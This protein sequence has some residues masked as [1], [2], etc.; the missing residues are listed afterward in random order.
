[1]ELAEF[2]VAVDRWLDEQ[3]RPLAPEYEGIGTLDQQMAQ[4]RKVM[5][6]TYEAGFMRMGWPERVGGLGGSNLLRA[7]L[8]EVLTARDIVEPGM[9]SMP[10]VLAPTMIDYAPAGL[11]AQMVP[12]LL[13]GE[14]T[15]CQGFSEP[16]TGSNLGSLACRA[17]PADDGWTVQGQKVWTS[18]AQYAARCVLLARTGTPESAHRG[19]T[20]FFVDMDSPGVTIRPIESMHGVPEFNE[21]FFDDVF[22]PADRVLGEVNQGWSI[23]MDLLPY[24]R[25]T[26]LWHRAAYLRRRL[27]RLVAEAPDGALDPGAAGEAAQLLL[28]FRARSRATQRRLA[29]GE[30]LGPETSVDK[31][32]LATAEQAVFDL[33]AEGLGAEVAVGDDPVSARWRAEFLY[34]RAASIYGGSAEIQRN[35]IARRLLGLGDDR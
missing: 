31:V 35:I 18:L 25:S 21:V 34:S 5:R 9:Y 11:A 22:V 17:V 29:A 14:E 10:E 12:K 27:E 26:A 33:A 23:A 15:W 2:K 1:M 30:T 4:L 16:G 7:Y 24:E 8:G 19:I 32:L 6:L 13:R 28:A 20:A 3:A